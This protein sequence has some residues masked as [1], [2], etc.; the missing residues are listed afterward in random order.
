MLK[1]SLLGL[2]PLALAA[3]GISAAPAQAAKPVSC[4]LRMADAGGAR[5][6]TAVA[7]AGAPIAAAYQL[8]MS[9]VS[10]G[11]TANTSQGDDVTLAAGQTVLSTTSINAGAK[12]TARLTLTW[13][14]GSTSCQARS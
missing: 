7:T 13:A 10:A 14:G 11:G 8:D 2:L 1:R 9:A 12:V 3:A 5:Q 4:E 6:L